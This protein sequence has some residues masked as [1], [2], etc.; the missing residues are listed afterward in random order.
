MIL[1]LNPNIK[2]AY[3]KGKWDSEAVQDGM[4]HLETVVCLESGGLLRRT[5]LLPPLRFAD[6]RMAQ[7]GGK[8]DL[9]E[10]A[11]ISTL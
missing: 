5:T 4:V 6:I 8:H 11:T 1:V 9:V 3:V 7:S 10:N 2:L